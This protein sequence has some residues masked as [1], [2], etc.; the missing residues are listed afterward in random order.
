MAKASERELGIGEIVG[1]LR[2]LVEDTACWAGPAVRA[3]RA[4]CGR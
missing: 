3:A 2:G 1:D 4:G